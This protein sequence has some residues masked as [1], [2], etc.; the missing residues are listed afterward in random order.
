MAPASNSRRLAIDCL[1]YSGTMMTNAPDRRPW[2]GYE[3]MQKVARAVR[4]GE[5]HPREV[6]A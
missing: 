2:R 4:A 6:F 1:V 5:Q 3:I